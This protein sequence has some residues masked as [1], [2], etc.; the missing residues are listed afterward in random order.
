MGEQTEQAFPQICKWAGYLCPLV[1]YAIHKFYFSTSFQSKFIYLF[2]Y[3]NWIQR[4]FLLMYIRIINS[5]KNREMLFNAIFTST[6]WSKHL[7]L[8]ITQFVKSVVFC[9][10]FHFQNKQRNAINYFFISQLFHNAVV[11]VTTNS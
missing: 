1:S 4:L 5:I 9:F 3:F 7:Y 2:I 6:S 11:S 10:V 8:K